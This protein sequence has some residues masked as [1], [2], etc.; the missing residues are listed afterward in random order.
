MWDTGAELMVSRG[1]LQNSE[2]RLQEMLSQIVIDQG[3]KEGYQAIMETRDELLR[4]GRTTH[5]TELAAN[6]TPVGEMT[7]EDEQTGEVRLLSKKERQRM[8]KD[9]RMAKKEAKGKG[10]R[11]PSFPMRSD[12]KVVGIGGEVFYEDAEGDLR[13]VSPDIPQEEVALVGSHVIAPVGRSFS[14]QLRLKRL[15]G[16]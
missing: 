16:S 5:V 4:L 6:S 3:N 8:K 7:V 15:T 12:E 2:I 10:S 1:L 13:D 9:A 14:Y 11:V